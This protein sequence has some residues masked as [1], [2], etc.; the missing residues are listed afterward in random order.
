MRRWLPHQE[1]VTVN[2]VYPPDINLA[3]QYRCAACSTA[4]ILIAEDGHERNNVLTQVLI[5]MQHLVDPQENACLDFCTAA[6]ESE[7]SNAKVQES[8]CILELR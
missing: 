6:D 4:T 1:S 2:T 7:H 3:K 5:H 8:I